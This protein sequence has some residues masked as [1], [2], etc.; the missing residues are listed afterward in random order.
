M[1]EI[2]KPH[3]WVIQSGEF[4]PIKGRKVRRM[5]SL[6]MAD[7]LAARGAT[8]TR[9][10]STFDHSSKSYVA[11]AG[12]VEQTDASSEYRLLHGRSF[13][14]NVSIRRMLHQRDIARDFVLRRH[15]AQKPDLIVA[16][17][18]TIDLADAAMSMAKEWNV[19]GFIDFRDL[20]PEA[21]LD[22]S[23]LPRQ[24]SRLALTPLYKQARRALSRA[25]G[26]YS[27][28]PA[29][30]D[31][32]LD[33]AGRDQC[34]TDRVFVLAYKRANISASE[35]HEAEKFWR[36]SGLKLD[37]TEV[38][39]CMFGNLSKT[40]QFAPV[41]NGMRALSPS[42]RQHL[43][44]VICGTGDQRSMLKES[45]LSEFVLPGFVDGVKIAALMQH[46]AAG[47]LPY[48]DR[49]DLLLSYPNKI[50]EYL[51]GG[52]PVL[53]SLGGA[54]KE[55]IE[56]EGAGM[57]VDAQMPGAWQHALHVIVDDAPRL[58]QMKA[59]AVRL[60][61]AKFNADRVYDATAEH[62]LSTIGQMEKFRED[63]RLR[64]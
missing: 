44:V 23:P 48:P 24:I 59:A 18:P 30:L 57:Y 49:G 61:D 36:M 8:V 54:A 29:F 14:K 64:A 31:K 58:K 17:L 40:V 33:L 37:G 13:T 5:R 34:D 47:L 43:K 62:L 7:A 60:Y 3:V 38:I 11:D 63:K 41:I 35:I 53:T 25:T 42:I 26:I 28:T 46:S 22:V 1:T 10:C 39:L 45:G 2:R 20:W 55:L 52:L 16:A 27:I 4:L 9:W 51:S 50:G 19:P 12:Y 21:F 15:E 56:Q 6:L 32:A